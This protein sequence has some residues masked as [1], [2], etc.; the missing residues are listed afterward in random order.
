[1]TKDDD[2]EAIDVVDLT[3]GSEPEGSRD[4]AWHAQFREQLLEP[5]FIERVERYVW[6]RIWCLN[7]QRCVKDHRGASDYVQDALV[8]TIDGRIAWHPDRVSL[9]KHVM[10]TI[11]GRTAKDC[12]RQARVRMCLLPDEQEAADQE[13][14]QGGE[15][16]IERDEEWQRARRIVDCVRERAASV[17]DVLL[18]LDAFANDLTKRV[19]VMRFTSLSAKRYD[20][21]CARLRR[22]REELPADLF[23][24]KRRRS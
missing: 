16:A 9:K 19:D 15:E 11:K 21:A 5:N 8:D 24:N 20:A 6:S 23:P 14:E 13:I 12:K 3:T 1:M 2:D 7:L 10:D 18:V 17:P 22:L 4:E